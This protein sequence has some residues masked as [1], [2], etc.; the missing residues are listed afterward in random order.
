MARKSIKR[1]QQAAQRMPVTRVAAEQNPNEQPISSGDTIAIDSD[2][3]MTDGQADEG[4]QKNREHKRTDHTIVAKG[5]NVQTASIS[6]DANEVAEG[7]LQA[8]GR[9]VKELVQ[10]IQ[11]LRYLGVEDLILPLPKIACVGDQSA[12]KSSLIEG[13]SGIKV[14]RG[15]GTCTRCPLEI[16]LCESSSLEEPWTCKVSLHKKYIYEGN[17][18]PGRVLAKNASKLEGATRA[19]PFGPWTLQESEEFHFATLTSKDEVEHVI[20]LAQLATLNPGSPW[21]RYLPSNPNPNEQ[22]QVKFSPNVIRLDISGPELPNLSFTDLPGVISDSDDEEVYLLALVQNL[23]KDYVKA[24]D[25]INVLAIPM[26]HDPANSRASRLIRELKAQGRTIGCLTKPD[27]MQVGES[28][29]QWLGILNGETFRLGFGYHVIKNNPDTRV[30]H[31]TAR[32]EEQAFFD[33]EEPWTTTLSAYSHRFGTLQLVSALSERLTA[34]I[35]ASLPRIADQVQR[36]AELIDAKLQELPEPIDGNLPAIVMG[37]LNRFEREI[38]KHIDGGSHVNSFQKE[39]NRLARKF[40]KDLADTRPVLV[41][42]PSPQTPSHGHSSRGTGPSSMSGTP[43]PTARGNTTPIPIDSDDDD[44]PCKPSPV[45]QRSGQKR[46]L[47][48]VQHTPQKI[49]RTLNSAPRL[50]ALS[51]SRRFDLSEVRDIIQDAYIGLPNQIDP[52]AT[53]RMIVMSMEHWEEPVNR[54]LTGT[55]QLCEAMVFEQVEKVFG[56]YA[57]TLFYEKVMKI[58]ESFFEEVL[59][60]Q[61]QLVMQVLRWETSKPKTFNDES[62]ELA[63]GRALTMLQTKRREARAGAYLDEQEAQTGKSTSGQTRIEKIS[64]LSDAQL[65]PETYNREIVAMSTVKGYYECAYSRFVDVV[66]ASIHCEL[67]NKCRDNIGREMK[68]QFGVIEDGAYERFA[69]LM[70]ANPRDEERR[71]QLKKERDT[72]QKARER[73]DGLSQDELCE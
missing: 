73:L 56:K 52:K 37:E 58:C 66:C 11:E 23:V 46:P 19:R 44:V 7:G 35:R 38:E 57:K 12:G 54:F 25:C 15:A 61:R 24:E 16:N 34:Q 22:H 27:R 32:L 39:W 69:I 51:S 17:L 55:K 10:A 63:E 70:A 41:L 26:T 47:A 71:A 67:F 33:E 50:T 29:D 45:V 30:D 9:G 60:Q 6:S 65:G 40:R 43:T 28:L 1:E 49:P 68:Q 64:K 59:S 21:E 4:Y 14:P 2:V 20:Y 62:L 42:M 5:Q 53:E 3:T 72:I 8:L 36:K 48:S 31:A 18:V 13:I